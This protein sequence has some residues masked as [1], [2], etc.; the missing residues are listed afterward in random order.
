M[1]SSPTGATIAFYV[2]DP[3]VLLASGPQDM[4]LDP[5]HTF[6][7]NLATYRPSP[8]MP[9][10]FFVRRLTSQ[11]DAEAINR[12]YA[13]R[14]MV[15]I[16]PEFYWAQRDARSISFFVAEDDVTG[17]ILGTV[18]GID[19]MR[20]FDDPEHGSSLWCLA[21]DPQARQPGVGE[22]LVR[23]LAEHYGAR[24]AAT[25]DLSVLHDN[26]LA[27]ALYEKLGFERVPFFTVKRKNPNKR[28]AV[29]RSGD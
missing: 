13:S 3:H 15:T 16:P 26:E 20:A 18:M 25:L 1:R 24:G 4:F 9:Q 8:R 11:S 29:H 7:L 28:D 12:I 23:R 27:I 19:H 14:G 6:R 5:S 22:A 17:D 10:G 21:V 2:R